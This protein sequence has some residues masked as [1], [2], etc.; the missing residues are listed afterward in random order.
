[1]LRPVRPEP[2]G[3]HRGTKRLCKRRRREPS[4][5]PAGHAPCARLPPTRPPAPGPRGTVCVGGEGGPRGAGDTRLP[6]MYNSSGKGFSF[7]DL[8]PIPV[9]L[10][11]GLISFR[12]ARFRSESGHAV[13]AL[14]GCAVRLC[15]VIGD[16]A[17]LQP[18]P[19]HAGS[20]EGNREENRHGPH[21][22]LPPQFSVWK[23]RDPDNTGQALSGTYRQ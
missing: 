3:S 15:R 7:P 22:G 9:F 21:A 8:R 10:R 5:S 14:G 13:S 11:T 17:W 18:V 19:G 20:T 2:G 23:R 6:R 16:M 1:M 12:T 4:H